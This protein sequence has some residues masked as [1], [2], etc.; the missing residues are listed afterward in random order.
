MQYDVI[1]VFCRLAFRRIWQV[2]DEQLEGSSL[3]SERHAAR[4]HA[5]TR[6]RALR[7]PLQKYLGLCPEVS[8]FKCY[9]ES[10]GDLLRA[11]VHLAI[12]FQL[13]VRM[14]F[15]LLGLGG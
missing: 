6:A 9:C 11:L 8:L 12:T 13:H 3:F 5:H 2:L 10:D 14:S 15:F 1:T 7:A 4:A